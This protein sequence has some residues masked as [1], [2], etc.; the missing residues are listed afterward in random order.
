MKNE[1][2]SRLMFVIHMHYI[3]QIKLKIRRGAPA[4]QNG[5]DPSKKDDRG[6]P[7]RDVPR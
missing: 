5:G 3:P 6:V 7:R 2:N 4:Y 1:R